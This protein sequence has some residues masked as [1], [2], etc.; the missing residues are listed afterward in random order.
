M[1][2]ENAGDREIHTSLDLLDLSFVFGAKDVG[3]QAFGA[4]L[5]GQDVVEGSLDVGGGST[6]DGAH[7]SEHSGNS[8]ELHCECLVYEFKNWG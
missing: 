5:N 3:Q 8:S 4:L 2:R 7:H 6:G 1:T